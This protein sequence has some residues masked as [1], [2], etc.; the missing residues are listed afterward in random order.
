M[1]EDRGAP[2]VTTAMGGAVGVFPPCCLYYCRLAIC[3]APSSLKRGKTKTPAMLPLYFSSSP[4]DSPMQKSGWR[5]PFGMMIV[6]EKQKE[7]QCVAACS[8][9]SS[10]WLRSLVL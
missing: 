6:V 8:N 9:S 10:T 1:K 2:G 7:E 3:L 5:K 4:F